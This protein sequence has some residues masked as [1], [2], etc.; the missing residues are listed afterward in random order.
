MTQQ[1]PIYRFRV[2]RVWN[3]PSR[4]HLHNT[5]SLVYSAEDIGHAEEHRLWMTDFYNKCGD[6][7][8]VEDAGETIYIDREVY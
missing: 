8:I 1:E 4:P 6:T 3:M 5:K 7:Y 2:Y